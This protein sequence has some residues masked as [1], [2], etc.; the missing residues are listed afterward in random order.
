MAYNLGWLSNSASLLPFSTTFPATENPISQGGIWT[1]GTEQA[2]AGAS[3]PQTTGGSPGYCYAPAA[4]GIDYAA[5]LQSLGIS[6]TKHYA[7]VTIK[8]TGGYTAPDTQEV[9]LLIGATLGSGVAAAYEMALW[10]AG[11][12]LQPVRWNATP[13]SFDVGV[14]TDLTSSAGLPGWPGS[15]VDGD[16]V[17]AEFDSTSGSPVITVYVNGTARI[18]MSD[19]TAG[20]ITSGSPGFGFFVRSGTGLDMTGYC[21]KGFAAGSL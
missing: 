7:Q 6:T 19:T 2:G 13:G 20:K 1:I 11:S 16:V 8:R 18:K 9:E 17:R 12:T 15:L 10:F 5:T 14:F 4:D 21:I 3:G